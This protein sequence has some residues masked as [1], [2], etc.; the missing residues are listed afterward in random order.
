LT[1]ARDATVNLWELDSGRLIHVLAGHSS[2]V[3]ALAI[4]ADG[5]YALSGSMDRSLRFWDLHS[6]QLVVSFAGHKNGRRTEGGVVY[7][8]GGLSLD[9]ALAPWQLRYGNGV[10]KV[11]R[12]LKLPIQVLRQW[13]LLSNPSHFNCVATTANG[14]CAITGS[15]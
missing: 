10:H 15:Q 12:A 2:E 13:V 3:N 4:S 6:G 5:H 9:Q 11:R 14:R 1:G 7:A 8:P